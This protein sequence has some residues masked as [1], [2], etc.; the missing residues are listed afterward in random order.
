[1]LVAINCQC[2]TGE[3]CYDS[4]SLICRGCGATYC[5]WCYSMGDTCPN[6]QGTFDSDE[7]DA[8]F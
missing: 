7:E 8:T 5:E 2:V 4:A 3:V 6:C 1:M